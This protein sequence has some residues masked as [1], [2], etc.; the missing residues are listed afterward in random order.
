M[1]LA[2]L[3]ITLDDDAIGAAVT[4]EVIDVVAGKKR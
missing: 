3:S 1:R 4:R 2:R